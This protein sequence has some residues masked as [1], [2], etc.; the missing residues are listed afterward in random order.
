MFKKEDISVLSRLSDYWQ[1]DYRIPALDLQVSR[2]M[3][4]KNKY[5]STVILYKENNRFSD[6]W[7]W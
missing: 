7:Y 4:I 2:L 1:I 5:K 6:Q 3:L